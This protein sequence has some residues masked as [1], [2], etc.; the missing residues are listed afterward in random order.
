[1]L[2]LAHLSAALLLGKAVSI[3]HPLAP[4]ELLLLAL[5]SSAVDL[6]YVIKKDHR[7]LPTHSPLAFLPLFLLPGKLAAITIAG[8]ALHLAL[9]SLDYGIMAGY[10]WRRRLYGPKIVLQPE[11]KSL[12]N[13]IR[14]YTRSRL[15]VLEIILPFAALAIYLS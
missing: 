10:P 6:D 3:W 5:S 14:N 1:M 8:L 15:L 7:T 11:V 9:D 4:K 12:Q 13:Y 2:P